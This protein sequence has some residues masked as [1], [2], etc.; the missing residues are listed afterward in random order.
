[1]SSGSGNSTDMA[2]LA[3]SPKGPLKGLEE[4][5]SSRPRRKWV[6]PA[7]AAGLLLGLGIGLAVGLPLAFSNKRRAEAVELSAGGGNVENLKGTTRTYYL[8]ADPIDWDY[9]P[10][11][12][13][14]C[15]GKPFDDDAQL[16]TS[17]GLG[18]KYKKA[19]YRQY[20]DDSFQV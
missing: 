5:A 6:L 20:K 8:A 14:L 11:G 17:K 15:N 2:V 13:N 1:M 7:A 9:A 18:S 12:K 10:A 19:V 3:D 4:P 16:Y